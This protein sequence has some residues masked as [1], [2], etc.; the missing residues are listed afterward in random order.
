MALI[1][2]SVDLTSPKINFSRNQDQSFSFADLLSKKTEE[3]LPSEENKPF[4]FSINNITINQ[5]AIDFHDIFK[6][7]KNRI[8]DITFSIPVISNLDYEIGNYIEPSFSANIN[9]SKFSLGGKTKPFA[10]SR[11]TS[12]DIRIKDIKIP[13]YL[14]YIP[15]KSKLT[16]KSATLD[17]DAKLS[18]LKQLDSN[19]KLSL[20][21]L[22]SLRDLDVVDQ[23]AI[24]YLRFPEV[25]ITMVDS[26]LLEKEVNIANITIKK[27]AMK[28][29][30]LVDGNILPISLITDSTPLAQNPPDK[31]NKEKSDSTIKLNVA[32]I[33]IQ[34]G[35]VHYKDNVVDPFI[36]MLSP[37]DVKV[38]NLSTIKNKQAK[39]D[40]TVKTEANE[41]L[42][43]NGGL[44][45]SPLA[46]DGTMAIKNIML[47]KY[48]PYLQDMLVPD[49]TSGKVDVQTALRY[50]KNNTVTETNLNHLDITLTDFIIEDKAKQKIIMVPQLAILDAELDLE[51]KTVIIGAVQT[52]KADIHIVKNKKGTI[53][54]EKIIRLPEKSQK[55]ISGAKPE[56]I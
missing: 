35:S 3:E 6:D 43:F 51:E 42:N 30:R 5:G 40:V 7:K 19:S 11:E 54:L 10:N 21:G 1:I 56:T 34:Q 46:I 53:N 50:S 14:G 25:K 28:L 45:I 20:T 16:L 52:Q 27:P 4:L 26:N 24:S 44:S 12:I 9:N 29:E 13:E 22:F 2:K 31:G 18:Y 38:I 17:I 37:I 32:E 15:I 8:T 33:L 48:V 49:L 55:Q 39:I 41:S 47:T 36:S 23:Q